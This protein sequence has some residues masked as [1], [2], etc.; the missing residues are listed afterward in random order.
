MHWRWE[1]SS[2]IDTALLEVGFEA[3]GGW[4]NWGVE[5]L[6][7]HHLHLPLCRPE[8]GDHRGPG[9]TVLTD[10]W[11]PSADSAPIQGRSVE[12]VKEKCKVIF[13]S[14]MFSPVA[15]WH[16]S[17]LTFTPHM[18]V[19]TAVQSSDMPVLAVEREIC[20]VPSAY[21]GRQLSSPASCHT[22]SPPRQPGL[23]G[24]FSKEADYT[25]IDCNRCSAERKRGK[26]IARGEVLKPKL[27][28]TPIKQN[29]IE[30]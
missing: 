12:K 23:P 30:L 22:D 6:S 18:T 25:L 27:R 28:G 4:A 19:P 8:L 20:I 5:H 11:A 1:L 15:F 3:L 7:A 26:R 9:Q 14:G 24:S 16:T 10:A 21:L 2:G 29:F 13:S 17:I